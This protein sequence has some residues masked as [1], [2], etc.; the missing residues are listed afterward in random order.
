MSCIEYLVWKYKKDIPKTVDAPQGT[1]PELVEA[2]AAL[3]KVETAL[4]RCAVRS[5]LIATGDSL[6]R[7]LTHMHTHTRALARTHALTTQANVRKALEDL[8]KLEEELKKAIEDLNREEASYKAKCDA[9]QAIVDD[10]S[11]TSIGVSRTGLC[12]IVIAFVELGGGCS[13]KMHFDSNSERHEE[14]EGLE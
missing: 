1:S 13:S 4:V 5:A 2:Q 7:S 3:Q 9:L 10:A 6:T 8:A 14:I 12:S 11:G